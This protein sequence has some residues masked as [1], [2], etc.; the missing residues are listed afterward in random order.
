M[1]STPG[2]HPETFLHAVLDNVGVALLVI[3][4]EGRFVFTNQAALRMFGWAESLDGVSLGEWRRGYVFRDGRGRPI[5][6]EQAPIMRALAGEEIPPQ[7]MDVTLPDGRRKWLHAAGHHFSVFGMTGVFVIVTDE[8]EQI[9]LRRAFEQA[10]TTEVFSLLVRGL[11]H[12]INNMLSVISGSVALLRADERVPETGQAQLEQMTV[13]VKRGGALTKRLAR[14]SRTQELQL[15]SAQINDLVNVALEVV[16]P[17]LK[18]RVSVKTELGFV[19]AV[20]VDPSRIEQALLNLILNALDAMPDGGELTLRTV[21]IERLT[22]AEVESDEDEG[23][24][25]TPFVCVTV[26]DTGIGIP[27]KL[28]SNIFDPFFTTK[29]D[30]TGSGLGLASAHAIVR[31]HNGFIKVQ[32]APGAGAKFNIYLPAKKN[33]H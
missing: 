20:E 25:T 22:V 24:P 14:Y 9:W 19:P 3:D 11:V 8:T 21:L 6:A 15:R 13:A 30:G 17:L 33:V 1:L 26:A 5:P 23:K 10:R 16:H 18:D 31:Q 28:Q 7:E 12:D 27:E 4:S 2:L 29:P 32:S